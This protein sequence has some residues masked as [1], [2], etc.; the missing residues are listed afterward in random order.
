MHPKIR[1]SCSNVTYIGILPL[2]GEGKKNLRSPSTRGSNRHR[3][4]LS[5]GSRRKHIITPLS[6]FV[7]TEKI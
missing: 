3:M 6:K 7:N 1:I 2:S 4:A 5:G